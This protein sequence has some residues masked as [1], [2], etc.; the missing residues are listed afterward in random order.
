MD[1]NSFRCEVAI[2]KTN[3]EI[4]TD[5]EGD[6]VL[7]RFPCS[8]AFFGKAHIAHLRANGEEIVRGLLVSPPPDDESGCNPQNE[9][10]RFDQDM[11]SDGD[12]DVVQIVRRGNCTFMSKA[13][14]YRHA[15][16]ILV[17]NTFGNDEL[18]IMA[19]DT[20]LQLGESNYLPT[21]VM[22]SGDDGDSILELIA[23][24]QSKGNVVNAQILMTRAGDGPR[25][26]YVNGSNKGL[27]VLASN[28]WGIELTP[29]A[30]G[31]K[32]FITQH[33]KL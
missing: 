7:R 3:Q 5:D 25:F 32:L 16:G 6:I 27:S 9:V 33:T 21:S 20:V 11:C 30:S 15:E 24:E 28:G 22:V 14:N 1:N 23:E 17:I 19:G 4:E 29:Q 31:W 18:F 8:P 13:S 2:T 12:R 26:P 10:S